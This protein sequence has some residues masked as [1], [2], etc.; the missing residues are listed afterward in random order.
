[1]LTWV[2]TV[3]LATAAATSAACNLTGEWTFLPPPGTPWPAYG[4]T[5]NVVHDGSS[6]T[7]EGFKTA[8]EVRSCTDGTE[9][10]SLPSLPTYAHTHKSARAGAQPCVCCYQAQQNALRL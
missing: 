5:Y 8:V 1:M 7:F 3:A 6:V 10:L 9:G 2:G 4:F